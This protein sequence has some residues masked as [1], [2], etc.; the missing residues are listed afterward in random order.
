[1]DSSQK[2]IFSN[3]SRGK[4]WAHDSGFNISW[5]GEFLLLSIVDGSKTSH[6]ISKLMLNKQQ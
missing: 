4:K 1:M 5:L 2:T 6:L 3:D